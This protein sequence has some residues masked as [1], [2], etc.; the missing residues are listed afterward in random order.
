MI[1][2][3]DPQGAVYKYPKAVH[4]EVPAKQQVIEQ[5]SSQEQDDLSEPNALQKQ[6]YKH[7]QR[8][9][10]FRQSLADGF[11]RGERKTDNEEN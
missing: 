2:T 9:Q 3:S 5:N 6:L 11:L 1:S 7:E 8:T 4:T 10:R